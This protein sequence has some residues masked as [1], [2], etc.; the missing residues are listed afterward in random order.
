MGYE[1]FSS[2]WHPLKM[3]PVVGNRGEF[4]ALALFFPFILMLKNSRRKNED[5]MR[6]EYGFSNNRYV[7]LT[8]QAPSQL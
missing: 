4:L 3:H 2:P 8:T 6:K 5:G 7:H 1:G